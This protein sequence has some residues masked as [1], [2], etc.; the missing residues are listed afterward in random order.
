MAWG[1]GGGVRAGPEATGG[2]QPVG[3]RSTRRWRPV[4]ASKTRT[5]HPEAAWL[6]NPTAAVPWLVLLAG[7]TLVLLQTGGT[8]ACGPSAGLPGSHRHTHTQQANHSCLKG[9]SGC[10]PH[11]GE[12][13]ELWFVAALRV[14]LG[15]V[16]APRLPCA[17]LWYRNSKESGASGRHLVRQLLQEEKV[18]RRCNG[19]KLYFYPHRQ[20]FACH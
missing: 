7:W 19:I 11:S 17:A 8:P 9:F 2:A 6:P 3:Q 5:A 12:S 14:H 20:G 15:G 18:L 10:W 1:A 4:A 13:R 16:L